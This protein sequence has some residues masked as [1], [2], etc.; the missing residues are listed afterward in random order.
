MYYLTRGFEIFFL[1]SQTAEAELVQRLN[2]P[3]GI[4]RIRLDIQIDVACITW[5]TVE[6]ESMSASDKILNLVKVE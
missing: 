6:C 4:G 1:Q 5:H 3:A 2:Y